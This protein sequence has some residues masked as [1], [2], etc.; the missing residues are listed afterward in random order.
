MLLLPLV[1]NSQALI[2]L[3]KPSTSAKANLRHSLLFMA[4]VT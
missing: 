2:T 4:W 1:F 3:T